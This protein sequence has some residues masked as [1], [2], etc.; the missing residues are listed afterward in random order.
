MSA[1]LR[2]EQM[3]IG[4]QRARSKKRMQAQVQ[5]QQQTRLQGKRGLQMGVR[6]EANVQARAGR[7][8]NDDLLGSGSDA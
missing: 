4:G 5:A 8:F 2:A 1:L 3:A 6:E 7:A